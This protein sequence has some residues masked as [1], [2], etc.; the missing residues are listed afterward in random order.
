MLFPYTQ[1]IFPK[2]RWKG[3]HVAPLSRYQIWH[4]LTVTTVC[5]LV[6]CLPFYYVLQ[7]WALFSG[8]LWHP[9][10]NGNKTPI[11]PLSKTEETEE[12]RLKTNPAPMSSWILQHSL[13]SQNLKK[14]MPPKLFFLNK[15]YLLKKQC[16]IAYI[17]YQYII[18]NQHQ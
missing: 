16:V 4:L 11:T 8:V 17:F 18:K 13:I 5:Y 2:L 10:P 12:Q 1:G 15:K 6:S 9:R 3:R 7:R 14:I